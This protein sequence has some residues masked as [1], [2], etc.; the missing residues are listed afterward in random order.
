MTIFATSMP[1]NSFASGTLTSTTATQLL[2]GAPLPC[3]VTL[4]SADVTRKIEFSTNGGTKY[5]PPVLD[6]TLADEIVTHADISI[7]HVRF[8]GI[9]GNTW[10]VL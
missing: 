8:T 9:V 6:V 1:V 3:T 7:T 5:F 4:D 2:G 10:S